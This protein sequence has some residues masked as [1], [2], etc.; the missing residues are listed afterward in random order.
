MLNTA[1]GNAQKLAAFN[2]DNPEN[3]IS[4]M[5]FLFESKEIEEILNLK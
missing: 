2:L 4:Q 1:I 3:A 5:H